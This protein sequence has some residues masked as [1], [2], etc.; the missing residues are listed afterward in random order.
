MFAIVT[1]LVSMSKIPALAEIYAHP[2]LIY[3]AASNDITRCDP[4]LVR[5]GRLNR[6][7]QVPVP[8]LAELASPSNHPRLGPRRCPPVPSRAPGSKADPASRGA[9]AQFSESALQELRDVLL[10]FKKRAEEQGEG[11]GSSPRAACAA[12]RRFVV[13]LLLYLGQS[14]R[15]LLLEL[16]AT[17]NDSENGSQRVTIR[18]MLYHAVHVQHV[19]CFPM[20]S[21]TLH[22][23][24]T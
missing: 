8:G 5:A 22:C 24:Q 23:A 3:L 4:A 17:E 18:G 20:P 16:H 9:G 14:W 2:G 7:I 6:I 1:F 10:E 19:M 11:H 21:P 15:R 13:P 12:R